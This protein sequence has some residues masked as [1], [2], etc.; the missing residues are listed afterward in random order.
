M[1]EYMKCFKTFLISANQEEYSPMEKP[2]RDLYQEIT[3]KII[4]S[5]EQG[6]SPW[7]CPWDNSRY[8]GHAGLPHNAKMNR[9]YSGINVPILWATSQEKG[10]ASQGWLTFKQAKELG[11]AVKAGEKATTV[12]Y[13]NFTDVKDPRKA[14]PTVLSAS[15]T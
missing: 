4:L 10:Y 6:V 8:G 15:S 2:K 13:W 1:H 9:C 14:T 5:L 12:V 7:K 11:G 3:D